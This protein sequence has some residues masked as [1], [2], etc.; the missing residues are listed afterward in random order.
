MSAE[1]ADAISVLRARV[2][3][4]PSDLKA[5]F[6]VVDDAELEDELRALGAAA[7]FY[8]L[9]PANLIPSKEGALGLADDA[10]AIRCALDEVRRRAPERAKQYA[11]SAPETWD[12]LED[13]IKL[14]ATLLGDLWEPLRE[15][16]RTIGMQEWKGKKAQ[17][18]VTDPEESAWL[19]ATVDETIALRDVDD[20]A[21]VRDV[22]K[23]PLL[24]KL[25]ARL[26]TRKRA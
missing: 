6:A 20:A 26:G 2:A 1:N 5:L 8:N 10:I 11:Q 16:W 21:V 22:K 15:T 4:I 12:N 9:N 19:Y 7:I 25:A 24:A 13:E 3:S 23:E 14:L 18:C 17:N